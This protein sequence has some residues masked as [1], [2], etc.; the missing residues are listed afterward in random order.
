MGG[1][2][3]KNNEGQAAEATAINTNI[4]LSDT[5]QTNLN[6]MTYIIAAIA[7]I[8]VIE[9]GLAIYRSHQKTLKKRYQANI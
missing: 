1:G 4:A 3:S 6:S 2:A 7:I 9:L 8:K 5:N